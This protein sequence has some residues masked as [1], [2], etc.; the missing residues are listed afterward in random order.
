MALK[1]NIGGKD[2]KT[3]QFELDDDK[4]SALIGKKIG[5]KV[6]GKQAGFDGYEFEVTGGSDSSGFPMRKDVQ[7]TARKKIL[8]TKG[9]GMRTNRKGL[10]LRKTVAGNTVFENTAQVNLKVLKAG[11]KPLGGEEE[12]AAEASREEGKPT[13][14]EMP[15]AEN[16][17][18]QQG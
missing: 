14:K 6:S 2:G 1:A 7:G 11:K 3:Q 17:T 9:V 4:A 16:P 15:P 13:E 8:T 18:E 10:R 12:E 5:D